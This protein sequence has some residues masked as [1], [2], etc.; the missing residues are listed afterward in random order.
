L[1]AAEKL[2]NLL[3]RLQKNESA[4][5]ALLCRLQKNESALLCRL[6]KN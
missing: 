4:L 6:Q 3:C 2:M 5:P 1:P